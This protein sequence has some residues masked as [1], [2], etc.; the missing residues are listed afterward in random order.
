MGCAMRD[1][2]GDWGFEDSVLETIEKAMPPYL[3]EFERGTPFPFSASGKPPD[4]PRSAYE[5]IT[6]ELAYFV[7]NHN[8]TNGDLPSHTRLQLEACRIV[9]ASEVTFPEPNPD[10]PGAASWLRDLLLSS[11]DI[12]Q[13]ARF[14][15]IRSRTE[16]RLTLQRIK[17][18]NALFEACPLESRLQTFICDQQAMR[19][20]VANDRE[21]QKEASRIIM[22]MENELGTRPDFIANW[23]VGFL[24][25]STNWLGD[26][27]QRADLVYEQGAWKAPASNQQSYFPSL[28]EDQIDVQSH[29]ASQ[30]RLSEMLTARGNGGSVEGHDGSLDA[31]TFWLSNNPGT[32]VDWSINAAASLGNFPSLVSTGRSVPGM[33][34]RSSGV[35]AEE[36]TIRPAWLGTGIF[37][38]NDTNHYPWFTRELKRWVKAAMSPNNPICHVPSDEELRHQARCLLYNE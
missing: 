29:S 4:S 37:V 18:K 16:S 38:L 5:L 11:Q 3:I 32:N 10:S 31:N 25:S 23:L 13:Q 7:Q 35:S 21:L 22:Q 15:P 20:R 1:W 30:Q 34:L 24:N 26:F 8:D 12:T 36:S 6:L 2:V 17:G 9:F 19:G 28:T 27:R 33:P 14:G